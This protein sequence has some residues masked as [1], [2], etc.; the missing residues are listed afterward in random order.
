M[1]QVYHATDTTLN[2]QVATEVP[3]PEAFAWL[4]PPPSRPRRWRGRWQCWG[5]G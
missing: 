2:R 3:R 1:G 5:D 4:L